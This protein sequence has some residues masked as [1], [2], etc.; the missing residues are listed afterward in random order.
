MCVCRVGGHRET[1]AGDTEGGRNRRGDK[2]IEIAEEKEGAACWKKKLWCL[3]LE[4]KRDYFF[5]KKKK[6]L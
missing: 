4:K 1:D 6:K 5:W 2:E 3:G